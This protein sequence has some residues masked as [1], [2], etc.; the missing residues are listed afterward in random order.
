MNPQTRLANSVHFVVLIISD[1]M[2][3]IVEFTTVFINLLFR[4]VSVGSGSWRICSSWYDPRDVRSKLRLLG[5]S[6]N[7]GSKMFTRGE[8]G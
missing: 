2:S 4:L 1:P 3:E 5:C 8:D 7:S 6:V